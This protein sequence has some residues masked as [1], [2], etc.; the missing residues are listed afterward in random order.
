MSYWGQCQRARPGGCERADGLI[1]SA[2]TQAQISFALAHPKIYLLNEALEHVK[3]PVLQS[4]KIAVTQ[5]IHRRS[6]RSSGDYPVLM[7]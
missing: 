1:S 3:G 6:E 4:R 5:G 7:V 2:T